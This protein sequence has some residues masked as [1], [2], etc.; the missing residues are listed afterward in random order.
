MR[1][2]KSYRP[3]VDG[4][5]ALAVLA[6]LFFHAG[7]G[8]ASGGFVG[9]D[10]FFVISGYLI[11]RNILAEVDA[12]TFTLA[13]FYRRRARRILPALFTT[14]LITFGVSAA[15]LS[16]PDLE[17]LGHSLIYAVFSIAN[18]YFWSQSG[19]F[20]V[21]PGHELLLHTWSL[22]VEEQFYLVWP[23]LLLV[24]TRVR[25]PAVIVAALAVLPV[26]SLCLSDLLSYGHASAAFFLLPFR[27]FEFF[28]GAACVY[29]LNSGP[30]WTPHRGAL[31]E[32]AF[33]LGLGL[34]VVPVLR[35]TSTTRFPGIMALVPCLGT[36]LMI[37]TG[38]VSRS[39]C[40]L[41][42]R[43]MVG[44]GLISY[45]VYLWHWPLIGLYRYWRFDAL[46]LRER[47][48]LVLCSLMLGWLS[49]RCVETPFRGN[50]PGTRLHRR[51]ALLAGASVLVLLNSG[52][53]AWYTKGW[54]GRYPKEFFMTTEQI[55][56]ERAR[57]WD[58]F[59]KNDLSRLKIDARP[60]QVIVMG[61]SHAQDLVYALR[62]NGFSENITYL[63]VPFTCYNFGTPIEPQFADQCAT[64]KRQNMQDAVWQNAE[65]VFLHEDW[66]ETDNA[67]LRS[68]LRD[69]RKLTRAPIYLFGP[70]VGYERRVTELARAHGR[71]VTLNEY[72][73]QYSNVEER[74]TFNESLREM[75]GS[76]R[77]E[78][79]G[80]QFVD[81]LTTQCGED[82]RDCEV[83]SR[84]NG[85][86]LY[87]DTSHFTEQGAAEFGA[88]LKQRY[89]ALFRQL[90]PALQ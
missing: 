24:L 78:D 32:A 63:G 65:A 4:L 55:L 19:Y 84:R 28:V 45:S 1:I 76:M 25:K 68:L 48:V 57:Y 72:V 29:L 70:K 53:G 20:G 60:N 69:V 73:R 59:G 82:L 61:N 5:R 31:A 34:V 64:A 66:K 47:C 52:A 62:Q 2:D 87:F 71:L 7:F 14:L 86:F 79:P 37:C 89:P 8:W 56:A 30:R 58:N 39:A 81:V 41:R 33:L 9:V 22:S 85:K 17:V 18:F 77:A 35:Y 3:D 54:P 67:E 36:M 6:I 43:V 50:V 83:V 11:S 51:F 75:I 23:A 26:A 16:P 21:D 80:I 27:L 38:G 13:D 12:G 10:V 88:K 15:L 74:H 40:V 46:S 90:A 49:W 44:L 42:N